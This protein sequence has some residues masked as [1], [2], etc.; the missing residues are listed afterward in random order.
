MQDLTADCARRLAILAF[1]LCFSC[2]ALSEPLFSQPAGFWLTPV[3]KTDHLY[4]PTSGT[5]NWRFSQWNNPDGN[6]R[7]FDSRGIAQNKALKITL[8]EDGYT[9]RQ[10][11]SQLPCGTEFDS[12]A[13]PNNG[14]AFKNFPSAALS[15]KTLTEVRKLVHRISVRLVEEKVID[16]N[17]KITQAALLTA[18]VLS[19][20]SSDQ[21]FFYQLRL[22]TLGLNPTREYWWSQGK[23]GRYGVGDNPWAFGLQFAEMGKET[24][25]EIDLAPRIKELIQSGKYGIDPDLSRWT[26]RGH[27]HGQAIW[28]NVIVE[29]SWRGF[30]LTAE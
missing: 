14:R 7:G 24:S 22:R 8:K 6:A 19:N 27:Y 1:L 13:A 2:A 18:V 15:V 5:A 16:K 9:I 20:E 4:G 10:D 25:Y 11:G 17:C 23:N 29:S 21:R 3:E 26:I 30:S 12:F 28:G